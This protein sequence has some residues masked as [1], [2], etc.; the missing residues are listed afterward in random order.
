[1]KLIKL[2]LKIVTNNEKRLPVKVPHVR[3]TG[4]VL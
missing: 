1:M 4:G 2:L 3:V